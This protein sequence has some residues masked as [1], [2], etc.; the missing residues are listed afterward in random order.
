MAS[1]TFMFIIN[2][3][4]ITWDFENS[5]ALIYNFIAPFTTQMQREFSAWCV[6]CIAIATDDAIQQKA[7][8]YRYPNYLTGPSIYYM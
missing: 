6:S 1:Y 5:I 2:T 7:T 4:N 3:I 8:T